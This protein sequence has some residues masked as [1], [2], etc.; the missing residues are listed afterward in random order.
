MFLRL[1]TD[2]KTIELVDPDNCDEFHLEVS[3]DPNPADIDE[4]IAAAGAGRLVG[5]NAWIAVDRLRQMAEGKVSE[6]WPT[7]FQM[8]LDAAGRNGWMNDDRSY[9]MGHLKKVG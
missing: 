3:G 8:M 1:D 9:V 5:P 2:A 4:T 7:R 6:D